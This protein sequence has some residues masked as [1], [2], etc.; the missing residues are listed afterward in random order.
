KFPANLEK[1]VHVN[2]KLIKELENRGFNQFDVRVI[3]KQTGSA[4]ENRKIAVQETNEFVQKVKESVQVR[5][6]ATNAVENLMDN[7]RRGKANT[8]EIM[9]FVDSIVKQ[10]S[11]DA[12]SAIASLKESD[13]TY[14]HCVDVGAIFQVVYLKTI[15]NMGLK[16][17]FKDEREML[18]SSF[19]HDFG[20]AKVPKEILDSTVRFERDSKE[21]QLMQA[22]PVYGAEMLKKMD[23]PDYIV[24]MAHYHHVKLDTSMASSYPSGVA[25]EDIRME[26][27]LIAII[28]IYQALVGKRSYKKSWAPPA[29]MKFIDQLSGVEYDLDIWTEFLKIMG[30]YPKG[31]AVELSDGSQAFVVS[32]PEADLTRPQ[33]V[34]VR[35]AAGEDLE[36]HTLIDLEVERDMSISKELDSYESFGENV[37]ELFASLQVI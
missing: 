35:N 28:D 20:K 5:E 34:Q 1:L 6:S 7:G 37:I 30:R 12:I 27:R 4:E 16:S 23:M 14:A 21:M 26:A 29:A 25:F 3:K 22:H 8:D 24:D 19:L 32:I 15:K 13:Q 31:S 17:V 10:S 36:H 18:L 9:E 2:D 33:V 11:A